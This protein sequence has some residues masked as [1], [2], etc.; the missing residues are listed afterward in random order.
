MR[1][2]KGVSQ[3]GSESGGGGEL[4]PVGRCGKK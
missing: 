2:V 3:I 4:K 1:E